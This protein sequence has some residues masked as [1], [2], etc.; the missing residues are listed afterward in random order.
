MDKLKVSDNHRYLI[1]H[2]G[3]P[4]FYLGDTA[5]ELFHRLDLEEAEI[6]LRDRAAKGFTVI[7]AVVIAEHGG[8]T[9]PN[10]YGHLPLS[11]MDPAR[12]NEPYFTHV[13]AIVKRAEELGLYTGMLPT[14]GDKWNSKWGTGPVIFTPSI[15]YAYGE[16][17]GR[18]YAEN[19]IIWILGGDRPVENDIHRD[20]IRAMA[21]GLREGDGGNHLMSFHPSGGHSS[22]EY[23]H[24]ES[25]L[26]FN[27]LQSGHE[28]NKDNYT[29]M[30]ADYRLSPVKPC[31]DAEPAY[32]DHPSGF[33]LNNGYLDDY[34]VRKGLYWSLFSGAFGHTYGCHDI[35]QMLQEGRKPVTF[36]RTPWHQAK[37]FPG[38]QQV[39]YA[40]LLVESRPYLQRIP[41]QALIASDPGAGTHHVRA[42]RHEDASYAMIYLASCKPVTIDL[43]IMSRKRVTVTWYDPRTG[44][45]RS[46][47]EVQGYGKQEFIPPLVWPDWVLVLDD[48]ECHYPPPGM[49]IWED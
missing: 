34:D 40:R 48:A 49:K 5:W 32:E 33:D 3:E 28:R 44:E 6:Y 21:M 24:E 46:G 22:S 14:W 39:Q 2:D 17:L 45:F 35:W 43:D 18:R 41:D 42:T 38:A 29:M 12:P 4:F 20:I 13:D 8:L 16:W 26:D 15:A 7:Q 31:M 23:W 36:A 37:D 27:M 30:T 25:W 9:V 11:D 10:A 47:G 19:D 1:T